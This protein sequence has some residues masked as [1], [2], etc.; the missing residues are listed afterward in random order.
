M[1]VEPHGTHCRT[2]GPIV[3]WDFN[4]LHSSSDQDGYEEDVM[5]LSTYFSHIHILD[6]LKALHN[7]VFDILWYVKVL[8]NAHGQ[9]FYNI[10]ALVLYDKCQ[11]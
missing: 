11:I 8:A 2:D 10:Q 7:D 9:N 1:W 3:H 6:I 5:M 4:Q